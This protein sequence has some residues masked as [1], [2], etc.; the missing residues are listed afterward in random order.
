MVE[1]S[2]VTIGKDVYKVEA[3]K[4]IKMSIVLIEIN[5]SIVIASI[6]MI[7]VRKDVVKVR[8]NKIEVGIVILVIIVVGSRQE[9]RKKS[10]SA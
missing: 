8:I 5:I 7:K 3:G 4:K 2:I 10:K 9:I 1:V 6:N